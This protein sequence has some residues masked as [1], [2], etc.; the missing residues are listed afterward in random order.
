MESYF[1]DGLNNC[2]G[3]LK[4]LSVIIIQGD[5]AHI[6]IFLRK[7]LIQFSNSSGGNSK[8]QQLEGMSL[9]YFNSHSTF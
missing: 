3:L 6:N 1:G 4:I 9:N 8:L 2:T 5:C 7:M